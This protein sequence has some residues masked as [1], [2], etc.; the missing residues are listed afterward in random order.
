MPD[1][2]DKSKRTL[3]VAGHGEATMVPDRCTITASLRV[4][5]ESVAD[6]IGTVASLADATWK[7][8]RQSG[9]ADSDLSTQNVHVQDWI[10]HE[11][12]RVTARVATYA[13]TI[14]V[15]S[16][17]E[18][19]SVVT[20]LAATAGDALQIQ[21]IGFSHSDLGALSAIARRHAVAD[22][23][24]RAQQLADAA[25]VQIGEILTI[26]EASTVSAGWAARAVSGGARLMSGSDMPMNPG[27]RSVTA[28]VVV[29]YVLN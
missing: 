20:L 4:M 27:T 22:A 8:L 16:L 19:S 14:D 28:H 29:T 25:G 13:F 21:A 23:A 7:A 12:R 2:D 5:S 6:A 24:A 3:V 18:V 1:G 26:D 17:H 15:R 11:Q 9:I 10:D